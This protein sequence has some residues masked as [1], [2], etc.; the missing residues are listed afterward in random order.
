[1]N[2]VR[3]LITITILLAVGIFLYVKINQG[4]A[5]P[6]AS[7]A[8]QSLTPTDIPPLGGPPAPADKSSTAAASQP[9]GGNLAPQWP[10]ATAAAN[11]NANTSKAPTAPSIPELPEL[12]PVPEIAGAGAA[13]LAAA[14]SST[15]P[16]PIAT[17][18][19]PPV[20][21]QSGPDSEADKALV[22][23]GLSPASSA[24]LNAAG[25][26]QSATP[27][28]A[29]AA[30]TDGRYGAATGKSGAA[31]SIGSA[32]QAP[33]PPATVNPTSTAS[34]ASFAASWPAI[35]TALERGDLARA[36]RMLSPW[37]S[38]PSLTPAEAE[39]V[40]TLLGQLAGS[41]IYSTEHRLEPP[42]VVK[43]GETLETIAKQLDVPWQLLAKING[44]PQADQ[45]RPGQQLKVVR[46]PFGAMIDLRRNQMALMVDGRYAGKFAVSTAPTASIP[47][48]EWV[49]ADKP[50]IPAAPP[51]V[52][53][54]ATT[55]ASQSVPSRAIRLRGAAGELAQLGVTVR[56]AAVDSAEAA[57]NSL[58]ADGQRAA[59][60]VVRVSP[61]DAEELSDILSVGSRVVIQR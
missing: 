21:T 28:T 32:A 12:P 4:P 39:R 1:M 44:I 10:A 60:Y 53:A 31:G 24:T 54:G 58:P 46:G 20:T 52:Y 47:P 48:G 9:A 11:T 27:P 5:R 33:A 38:D 61:R 30:P 56:I 18:L 19:A 37:F 2:S 45:L 22:A 51:S 35:Q 6:E 13:P 14:A 40:E 55:S 29:T 25:D 50:A 16:D 42:Y 3:P 36:H 57:A 15:T 41:V 23:M 34:A 43:P 59:P 26:S 49:V 7:D 17:P 8:A